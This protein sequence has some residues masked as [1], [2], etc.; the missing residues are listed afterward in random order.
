LNLFCNAVDG[1]STAERLTESPND[2]MPSAVTPDGTQVLFHRESPD[3]GLDLKLLMLG[4]SRRIV[5]LLATSL[6]K[7]TV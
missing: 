6:T 5:P 2:Q 3:N 4:P 7:A 1:T